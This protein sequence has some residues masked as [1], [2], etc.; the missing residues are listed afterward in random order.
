MNLWFF[1]SN[2]CQRIRS[3]LLCRISFS[4]KIIN[5]N[6]FHSSWFDDNNRK[7]KRTNKIFI[8]II[9]S[10]IAIIRYLFPYFRWLHE[11]FITFSFSLHT[12]LVSP[13]MT[14]FSFLCIFGFFSLLTQWRIYLESSVGLDEEKRTAR[15]FCYFTFNRRAYRFEKWC[16]YFLLG[17]RWKIT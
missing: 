5:E 6:I 4:R 3:D 1:L 9:M 8:L 17:V 10:N 15:C 7:M 14:L 16:T 11:W 13:N 2:Q 12:S